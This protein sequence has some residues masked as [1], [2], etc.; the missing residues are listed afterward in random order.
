MSTSQ[1]DTVEK[2]GAGL[3]SALPATP[4]SLV[5][6]FLVFIFFSVFVI[7]IYSNTF[8]SP[9]ILDDLIRIEE[10][11]VIRVGEFFYQLCAKP[12]SAPIR[13]VRIS[14]A[15][16]I[17]SYTGRFLPVPFYKNHIQ[18]SNSSSPL[19]THRYDGL[20]CGFDLA[21]TPD[22]NPGSHL[23]RPAHDQYGIPVFY[24]FAFILC[25][26]K[27]GRKP[28]FCLSLCSSTNGTFSRI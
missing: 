26:W 20:F 1:K 9:F 8:T 14:R 17:D 6:S 22:S 16:H 24:P 7:F 21:G 2:P 28:L 5:K 25:L 23:H 27:T 11:P 19:R 10:N 12:Q 4:V 13:R 18:D 15:Q 3:F